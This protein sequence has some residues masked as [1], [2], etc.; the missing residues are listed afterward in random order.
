MYTKINAKETES[1]VHKNNFGLIW[2]VAF[3]LEYLIC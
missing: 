2:Q 3:K 1:L